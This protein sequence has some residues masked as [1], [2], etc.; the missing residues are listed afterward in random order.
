MDAYDCT[1]IDMVIAKC[2]DDIWNVYDEDES[3]SLDREETKRFVKHTLGKQMDQGEFEILFTPEMFD[4]CFK[5][6]DDDESGYIDRNEMIAF[7]K[8]MSGLDT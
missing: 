3:G 4:A 1:D 7:I 2:V 6:F 5:E 8:K